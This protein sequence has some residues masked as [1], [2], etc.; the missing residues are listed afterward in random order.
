MAAAAAAVAGSHSDVATVDGPLVDSDDRSR[1]TRRSSAG[2]VV[3]AAV[4]HPDRS[5]IA[6]AADAAVTLATEDQSS[7]PS[8]TNLVFFSASACSLPSFTLV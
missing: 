4:S 7:T 2:A 8:C 1:S 6:V 5:Q 3:G